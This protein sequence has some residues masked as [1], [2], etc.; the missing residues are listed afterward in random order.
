MMLRYSVKPCRLMCI[1]EREREHIGS[2]WSSVTC[3]DSLLAA[4]S[5]ARQALGHSRSLRL[6]TVVIGNKQYKKINKQYTEQY[7]MTNQ[8]VSKDAARC[9]ERVSARIT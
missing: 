7:L 2:I 4:Q 1:L 8:T 5:L 6:L 9:Y 3:L